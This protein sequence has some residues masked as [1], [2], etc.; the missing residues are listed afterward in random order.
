MCI[1]HTGWPLSL[2]ATF[3]II[4][5]KFRRARVPILVNVVYDQQNVLYV[6]I[7]KNN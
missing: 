4:I 2:C 5:L 7:D 1:K 6:K 3:K